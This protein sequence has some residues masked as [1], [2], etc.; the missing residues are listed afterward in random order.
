MPQ[1]NQIV[2]VMGAPRSGTTLITSIL[3]SHPSVAITNECNIVRCVE[4][5]EKSLF[6]KRI[7]SIERSRSSRETWAL[8]QATGHIPQP[9]T[10]LFPIIKSF[11]NSI[12]PNN[13]ILLV[14]DKVPTYY[15]YN[16][17][18]FSTKINAEILII[19]LT[20][21][22]VDVVSSMIRRS[23]NSR[24]GLDTWSGPAKPIPALNYWIDAWNHR[25]KLRQSSSIKFL[26]LNYDAA[27]RDPQALGR[28]L[29]NFLGIDNQFYL[30]S[31][32]T[33]DVK[34]CISASQIAIHMPQIIGIDSN[35]ANM[36]LEL[37]S[38][39]YLF[40]LLRDNRIFS[41][42]IAAFKKIFYM[43][44]AKK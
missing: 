8:D 34:R 10:A 22:P 24:K 9:E 14:G 19:Y 37:D 17:S 2:L 4:V 32:N 16:L 30:D 35:W 42:F 11:C 7:N 18:E 25:N 5:F 33:A 38:Y 40:P 44:F 41:P 28:L 6:R 27:I 15:K 39:D 43:L 29:S 1:K 13:D 36:P 21:N 31:V 26:D 3:N 23:V 12:K 20:R